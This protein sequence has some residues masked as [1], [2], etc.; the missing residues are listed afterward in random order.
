M[1]IWKL[2]HYIP[3]ILILA[4]FIGVDAC[5]NGASW[6]ATTFSC[7]LPP[8]ANYPPLSEYINSIHITNQNGVSVPGPILEYGV[9]YE[10][11]IKFSVPIAGFPMTV[12]TSYPA[13]T[14]AGEPNIIIVGPP[15]IST[16]GLTVA[17]PI[18]TPAS[19]SGVSGSGC[20]YYP[21]GYQINICGA[22]S[23]EC[24]GFFSITTV[25][26][27]SYQGTNTHVLAG[28]FSFNVW[29]NN[30]DNDFP[31]IM[32]FTP[33]Y[34][35]P[36]DSYPPPV[37]V[38]GYFPPHSPINVVFSEIM[39]G[40]TSMPISMLYSRNNASE[41]DVFTPSELPEISFTR[42]DTSNN[43]TI[44]ISDGLLEPASEYMFTFLSASNL[45]LYH[46]LYGN[47]DSSGMPLFPYVNTINCAQSDKACIENAYWSAIENGI[48]NDLR[49][50]NTSLVRIEGPSYPAFSGFNERDAIYVTPT[51]L[52]LNVTGSTGTGVSAVQFTAESYLNGAITPLGSTSVTN[53][54]FSANV[55]FTGLTDGPYY[56]VAQETADNSYDFIP[57]VKDTVPPAAPGSV[58][59]SPT[60]MNIDNM[61]DLN[62]VCA[63][64]TTSNIE[65]A[66]LY[67]V[68]PNNQI[69]YITSVT[70]P[71]N[72]TSSQGYQFCFSNI[73]VPLTVTDIG[74]NEAGYPVNIL[75]AGIYTV[76]ITFV[77]FGGLESTAGTA[78]L[79]IHPEINYVIKDNA[80]A[81]SSYDGCPGQTFAVYGD[82]FNL[83]NTTVFV[84]GIAWPTTP[85]AVY[86]NWGILYG[87]PIPTSIALS[88]AMPPNA[89]SGY[90][91]VA[92]NGVA[93]V[94]GTSPSLA[95]T[96]V[97]VPRAIDKYVDTGYTP[98]G[99]SMVLDQFDNPLIAATDGNKLYFRYWDGDEW[100]D[101]TRTLFG[102]TQ[103]T[104]VL[105]SAPSLSSSNVN[106]WTFGIAPKISLALDASG[107][108][109]IAYAKATLVNGIPSVRI[110]YLRGTKNTDGT[111][112]FP[113]PIL[114]P[115][116]IPNYVLV[117]T[118]TPCQNEG[119]LGWFCDPGWLDNNYSINLVF[120]TNPPSLYAALKNAP[121][122]SYRSGDYTGN[123]VLKIAEILSS[124]Q[125][126]NTGV[127]WISTIANAITEPA[128]LC[129]G[130]NI[131]MW[132]AQ[133]VSMN[134]DQSGNIG[135]IYN[136]AYCDDNAA[137]N[138]S[139]IYYAQRTTDTNGL[140]TWQ[141]DVSDSGYSALSIPSLIINYSNPTFALNNGGHEL[142]FKGIGNPPSSWNGFTI[143][144]IPYSSFV[145]T[146]LG[147]NSDNNGLA[148]VYY[149]PTNK[150][151]KTA[152]GNNWMPN[153]ADMGI[154]VGSANAVAIDSAGKADIAYSDSY[155]G[156]LLFFQEANG[157]FISTN[158]NYVNSP[159]SCDANKFEK[160]NIPASTINSLASNLVTD[161]SINL[162]FPL[163]IGYIGIEANENNLPMFLFGTLHSG[164]A[165]R[166]DQNASTN[167]TSFTFTFYN[168]DNSFLNPAQ[169]IKDIGFDLLALEN[170]IISFNT[171][172]MDS[173]DPLYSSLLHNF[174]FSISSNNVTI[175][176]TLTGGGF[177]G[178]VNIGNGSYVGIPYGLSKPC[179]P[180]STSTW[181]GY[182]CDIRNVTMSD[183]FSYFFPPNIG[184]NFQL[185]VA[186][187]IGSNYTS[188]TVQDF[189]TSSNITIIMNGFQFPVIPS[190]IDIISQSS[191][192]APSHIFIDLSNIQYNGLIG[193]NIHQGALDFK[194]NMFAEAWINGGTVT[195]G[196]G[197]E[198]IHIPIVPNTPNSLIQYTTPQY[199]TSNMINLFAI[200]GT[201]VPLLDATCSAH[202]QSMLE[203]WGAELMG[204]SLT[205]G[206]PEQTGG[207]L[208]GLFYASQFLT[209]EV[210]NTSSLSTYLSTQV[211]LNSMVLSTNG[212]DVYIRGQ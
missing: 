10:L 72:M 200:D 135:L 36:I 186:L 148:V 93:S 159:T 54:Q 31:Y 208:S 57:V 202:I 179:P 94:P 70:L 78:Q 174:S 147:F 59:I 88:T 125:T 211:E 6:S 63:T 123:Q 120:D 192:Y 173:S 157:D 106:G 97:I 12:L 25:N 149:D 124:N 188:E 206:I 131:P 77:D 19:Q 184:A 3:V 27:I 20:P 144:T 109:A 198:G 151:L 199:I 48:P 180:G 112:S 24:L 127:P 61:Q 146:S 5:S 163:N 91:T 155:N 73:G 169:G 84:N 23:A 56:F 212:L 194:V 44:L 58:I 75:A 201:F 114:A 153:I 51:S 122:I 193:N 39:M 41:G 83:T 11:M 118:F 49:A 161:T 176:N 110:Y 92:T 166:I 196:G 103:T 68:D 130:Y 95:N 55:P 182:A 178:F 85:Y 209:N 29:L 2:R 42:T 53:N 138:Q 210:V 160:V 96:K 45:D 40:G 81:G 170:N 30:L 35:A 34:P 47:Q 79:K 71:A 137:P 152:D 191:G 80:T 117:D 17:I 177:Y 105:D 76:E 43:Q 142:I 205:F 38:S 139:Y 121:I 168:E 22:G 129:S 187:W 111:Y 67:I 50:F 204:I 172:F 156:K 9:Q 136:L 65:E 150:T 113:P 190:P 8:P 99:I 141:N 115:T 145:Y 86:T 158:P 14:C 52:S 185:M 26:A 154:N 28:G 104:S 183:F 21:Y 90:I 16:D 132:G 140:I 1:N 128:G 64:A 98:I 33:G 107:N 197:S 165:I 101:P 62:S 133:Y 207:I 181:G 108:P 46:S 66:Q 60:D 13:G 87:Q 4:F 69:T 175:T 162:P 167:P 37:P 134:K 164:H 102:S 195:C 15:S 32:S 74:Q 7:T 18:T 203:K 82:G 116:I 143:D 100:T 189:F 171:D 126:G 89:I 119:S